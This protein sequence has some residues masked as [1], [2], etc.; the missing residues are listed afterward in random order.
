VPTSVVSSTIKA[1]SLLAAGRA[2]GV[3]SAKVAALTEGVVK[4]MFMTK[5]KA[6]LV[7]VLILGFV[8]TGTTIFASRMAAGQEDQKPAA[9]KPVKPAAKQEKDKE[10]VTAWG[11]EVG[12]LQAGLGY[13]PGQKRTYSHGETVTLVV[14]VRNVGKEE[15]KFQYLR[16]FFIETPPVV[17][18]D[19]GKPVPLP[20]ATAVGIH[21]PLE[22]NLAPGKDI[23]LYELKLELKPASES[24]TKVDYATLYGTGK[25][26]VQYERV[27]GNS[28]S[29]TIKL[30]PMLSKLATGKLELQI[31]PMPPAATEK[32]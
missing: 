26:S 6:A 11:K 9:E 8:A 31:N 13:K 24:R 10:I 20:V 3:V 25:F 4:A 30:D 1:A 17:T 18:D 23:E 5:I 12:G 28:L 27:F 22:V 29:G 16:E 2:A 15:V 14:R 7:V 32:K 19:E 21:L